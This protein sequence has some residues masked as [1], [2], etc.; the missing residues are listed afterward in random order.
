M[1]VRRDEDISPRGGIG[2]YVQIVNNKQ[3][4]SNQAQNPNYI[5]T[6]IV[7]NKENR[8]SQQQISALGQN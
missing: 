6:Q 1:A 4:M 7:E 3:L 8:H 2:Q 5:Q